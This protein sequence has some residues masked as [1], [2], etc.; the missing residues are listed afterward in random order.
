MPECCGCNLFRFMVNISASA[1]LLFFLFTVVL[2][3][4]MIQHSLALFVVSVF[5]VVE[6]LLFFK[7]YVDIMCL[8]RYRFKWHAN[9][10]WVPLADLTA[11]TISAAIAFNLVE[12]DSEQALLEQLEQLPPNQMLGVVAVCIGLLF[13]LLAALLMTVFHIR[14]IKMQPTH[15]A[16]ANLDSFPYNPS[17]PAL[18]AL[19]Q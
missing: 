18:D 2:M 12:W 7:Y 1:S 4:N 6:S 16:Y 17:A 3:F 11:V 8:F 15:K 13:K 9:R 5:Y 10:V 14:L 19:P